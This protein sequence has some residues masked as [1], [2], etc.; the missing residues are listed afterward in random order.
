MISLMM[1]IFRSTYLRIPLFIIITFSFVFCLNEN[2]Y[3][4]NYHELIDRYPQFLS[5][6]YFEDDSYYYYLTSYDYHGIKETRRFK[7]NKIQSIENSKSKARL[8]ALSS[9]S[10]S[11]CCG[12]D[13]NDIRDLLKGVNII[14]SNSNKLY[15]TFEVTKSTVEFRELETL[16]NFNNG[17]S[18]IYAIRINKFNIINDNSCECNLTVN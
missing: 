13:V 3:F 9:L 18:I 1:M 8:Q 10:G 15:S 14:D 2:S 4:D 5:S 12:F 11:I 16:L 17:N 6:N 7:R